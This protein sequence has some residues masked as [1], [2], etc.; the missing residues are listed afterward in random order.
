MISARGIF[1]KRQGTLPLGVR[2][3]ATKAAVVWHEQAWASEQTPGFA[4]GDRHVAARARAAAAV[5]LRGTPRPPALQQTRSAAALRSCGKVY[6]HW[7]QL[8]A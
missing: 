5:R 8:K 1:H 6:R 2:A 3:A 7:I 4:G